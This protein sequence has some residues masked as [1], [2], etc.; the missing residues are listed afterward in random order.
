M[1]P[2]FIPAKEMKEAFGQCRDYKKL[3]FPM[4]LDILFLLVYGFVAGSPESGSFLG[5]IYEYL[6][7]FFTLTSQSAK[8]LTISYARDPSVIALIHQNPL[9]AHYFYLLLLAFF[10]FGLST[11]FLYCFFEG[12]AW[13]HAVGKKVS[14]RSYVTQFFAV[15]ILWF[16]I[17]IVYAAGSFVQD[18]RQSVLERLGQPNPWG[19]KFFLIALILAVSYFALV[20]YC[21]IGQPEVMRKAFSTGLKAAKQL[22]PAYLIILLL[23]AIIN[24]F[25][26]WIRSFSF[27]L[28]VLLGILIIFPAI[29]WARVFF[30]LRVDSAGVNS[31]TPT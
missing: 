20:S 10:L 17:F 3:S 24:Y 21:L 9:I 28:M 6:S 8:E 29:A 26:V 30:K 15:N 7:A 22:V 25:L 2:G 31:V 5:K 4:A 27:S 14:Y 18:Y 19:L 16:V 12:S 11:Y 23:F 13:Y 1:M